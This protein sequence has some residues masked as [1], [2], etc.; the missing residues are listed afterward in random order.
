MF[1]RESFSMM[2][3]ILVLCLIWIC[4]FND[5]RGCFITNCPRAGK[6]SIMTE[7]NLGSNHLARECTRCGPSLS[8]RCYGPNICCSP[9]T[10]CNIGGFTAARCSLEAYHPILCTNPGTVCGPNGKG[11]CALNA[12]CCTNDGCFIDKSCTQLSNDSNDL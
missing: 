3:I 5:V 7:S 8:G 2:K 6:R 11:V 12:T 10:G 9:L 4:L 1:R